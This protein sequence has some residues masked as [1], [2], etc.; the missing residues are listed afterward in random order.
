V[1]FF[2]PI[3]SASN[4]EIADF[5]AAKI[6]DQGA[7]IRVFTKPGVF[8]FVESR[9]IKACKSPLIFREVSRNPIKNYSNAFIV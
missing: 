3:K 2:K 7:P 9:S 1:K 6:E 8:M 5:I 4:E